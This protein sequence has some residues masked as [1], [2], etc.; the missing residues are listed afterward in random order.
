MKT[1]LIAA[2]ALLGATAAQAADIAVRPYAKAPALARA[3]SW[4]GFY[5]GVNVGYGWGNSTVSYAPNDAA[6]AFTTNPAAPASYD[7]SGILGGAQIGYNWHVSPH[8]VLGLEADFQGSGIKGSGSSPYRTAVG[9]YPA[10]TDAQQDLQWFGTLRARA[11]WL[12]NER[13]L[14]YATGG[15]A[16]GSVR[17]NVSLGTDSFGA[18]SNTGT[19]SVDCTFGTAKP[20]FVGNRSQILVGY[21]VGAGFEYAAWQ[22]VS[23]KLEYLYVNLGSSDVTAVG[24]TLLV[25]ATLPATA[26]AHFSALHFNVVRA[27]LNYRF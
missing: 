24:Q 3:D 20:C 21:A 23:V 15:L 18:G 22:N 27:G 9:P 2:A 7:I 25:P 11:G 13:L 16:Y 14:A 17:E 5:A 26:N 6:A 19:V 8:A 10:H 12:A 1:F 4:T